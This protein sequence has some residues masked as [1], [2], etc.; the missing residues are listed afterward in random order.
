MPALSCAKSLLLPHVVPIDEVASLRL[1]FSYV[2][3]LATA[4][5]GRRVQRLEMSADDEVLMCRDR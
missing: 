5:R 3:W 2:D 1:L 4:G